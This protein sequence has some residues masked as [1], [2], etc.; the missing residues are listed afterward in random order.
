MYVWLSEAYGDL[1]GFLQGWAYFVVVVTGALAALAVVF[2][3]YS[4]YF[5]PL[6]KAGTSAVAV[7][8]LVVLAAVNI[9]GVR[10]AALIG[11]AL[12]L[13]KL[14]MIAAI[15]GMGLFFGGRSGV[16]MTAAAPL[17]EGGLGAAMIGVLWSYGGWQHASFVAG[18]AKRAE[19]DVP[20]GMIVG[21]VGVT[22]VVRP[23]QRRLPPPPP[24]PGDH[25]SS[26]VASDAASVAVGPVGARH[27]RG[28]RGLERARDGGICT[29]TAPRLY[30]GMAERGLFFRGVAELHPVWRTPV[31]AIVLGTAWASFSSSPGARSRSSSATCSSSIDLFGLTGAAVF[32][33]RRRRGV[34]A[35]YRVPGYPVVPA[36]FVALSTWFVGSTLR[37]QPKQAL[38]G[39][40]FLA[41]GVPVHAFWSRQ[42]RAR[43]AGPRA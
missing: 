20:L 7:G 30:W 1:V 40:A 5:V 34:P 42:K 9:V 33:L 15:V 41:L 3:E 35:S 22:L 29:F 43:H 23:R 2:A 36:V 6:G 27:R 39:G 14:A 38:A 12:T 16:A 10:L 32:V 4:A 28:D 37:A 21:T 26:H 19:R 8:A 13:A 24:H 18:E 11:D 25:G 31:C 17:T